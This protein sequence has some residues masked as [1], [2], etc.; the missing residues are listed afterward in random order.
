M[1]I[2][3][4][5]EHCWEGKGLLT[6]TSKAQEL[7]LLFLLFPIT[8]SLVSRQKKTMYQM[9]PENP[10]VFLSYIAVWKCCSSQAPSLPL[11]FL[12]V[13]KKS[14]F[15]SF[16]FVFFSNSQMDIHWWWRGKE[17]GRFLHS[18]LLTN[19]STHLYK[20]SLKCF[21]ITSQTYG[22]MKEHQSFFIS[23]LPL[24]PASECMQSHN[25]I[26]ETTQNYTTICNSSCNNLL[27]CSLSLP[28][29]LSLPLSLSLC[30][31][32]GLPGVRK[33]FIV[34]HVS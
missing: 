28:P 18:K 19:G 23:V 16:F 5:K 30:F 2:S 27:A 33:P 20:A 1:N 26:S 24:S 34:S 4:T 17:T 11:N 29:S 14:F 12:S 13:K 32:Y 8:G 22:K 3:R 21:M 10:K 31:M 7:W 15:S 6:T 9:Q 25:R